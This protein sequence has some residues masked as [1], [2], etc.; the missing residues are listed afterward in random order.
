M[1][2]KLVGG[3]YGIRFLVS[4]TVGF[5]YGWILGTDSALDLLS[6]IRLQ[7]LDYSRL[8]TS[9]ATKASSSCSIGPILLFLQSLICKCIIKYRPL[10]MVGESCMGIVYQNSLFLL[11]TGKKWLICF[12]S[13]FFTVLQSSLSNARIFS[14]PCFQ[15]VFLSV[16]VQDGVS[17]IIGCKYRDQV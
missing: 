14:T 10:T 17:F 7:Y 15:S 1:I 8:M 11:C 9:F 6:L 5:E 3:R 16:S 4:L 13:P 12:I 2:V